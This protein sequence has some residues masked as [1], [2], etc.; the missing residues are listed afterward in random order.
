MITNKNGELMSLRFFGLRLWFALFVILC[1]C[2]G[3]PYASE[4][5]TEE[6]LAR[7]VVGSYEFQMQT[8]DDSL[9]DKFRTGPKP[10]IIISPN[11]TFTMHRMPVFKSLAFAVDAGPATDKLEMQNYKS[12]KAITISGKWRLQLVGTEGEG[13]KLKKHWGIFFD[14]VPVM[15]SSA[16]LLGPKMPHALIFVFGEVSE[17]KVMILTKK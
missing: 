8:V 15:I 4:Y 1:G 12:E 17:G 9:N 14:S 13:E 11:H 16:G 2:Q 10:V 7:D 6:P 3:D 5:T